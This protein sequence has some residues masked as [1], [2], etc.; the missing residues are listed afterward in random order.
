MGSIEAI[1]A[2]KAEL[3]AGLPPAGRRCVPAGEP[4]L[5][6]HLR[7]DVTIVTFGPG[8]DVRQSRPT[9]TT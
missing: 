2:A 6:P 4:L 9:A 3:I 5:D 8:G 7:A 1:A